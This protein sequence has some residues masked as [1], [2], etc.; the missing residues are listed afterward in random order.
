VRLLLRIGVMSIMLLGM[1]VVTS[2][3]WI[4]SP[5]QIDIEEWV[6][7]TAVKTVSVSDCCATTDTFIASSASTETDL[8][9]LIIRWVQIIALLMLT[10]PVFYTIIKGQP[11][12][13]HPARQ[14]PS[15]N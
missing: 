11:E 10:M 1:F 5:Y 7:Y 13:E 12:D 15:L 6:S 8:E 14:R 3:Q 2:I 9:T 4:P